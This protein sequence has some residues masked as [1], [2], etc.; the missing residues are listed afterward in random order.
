[1]N[2]DLTLTTNSS[3]PSH[4]FS[5]KFQLFELL[6]DTKTGK[7]FVSTEICYI[8]KKTWYGKNTG[9]V[10]KYNGIEEERLHRVLTAYEA[11]DQGVLANPKLFVP[12]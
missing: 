7:M 2:T 12:K 4:N 5:P 10:F 11:W 1:M 3:L 9:F 8:A 6:Q